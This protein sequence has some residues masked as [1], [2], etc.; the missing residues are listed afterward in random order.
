MKS[1]IKKAYK[2]IKSSY[3]KHVR[4]AHLKV[5]LACKK[6]WY[7]N[8]YGGFYLY[9]DLLNK[10]SIVYSF[11]I[12]EDISFDQAVID[13]HGCSV[14]GFDPTPKSINWCNQQDL[15]EGFAMHEY[16]LGAKT[17][18][19]QFHLP[20][21]TAHVSGSIYHHDSLAESNSVEVSLHSFKDIT[22]SLG[23]EKIDVL[24]MDIEG[25]EY[26]V[27]EGILSSGVVIDQLAIELHERFFE[28]GQARSKELV[29]AI[30]NAGY[31]LFAVSESYEEVSF[32]RKAAIQTHK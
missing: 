27:I 7:G 22:S 17:E 28:D 30:K 25:S 4:F 21:N 24:K 23:H 6:H 8:Q 13:I 3:L 10:Q 1:L 2:P 32:I 9:P 16:G 15:P 20:K 12:G 19:V 11:G 29:R 26:D 18:M 14:F 5:G 31:E